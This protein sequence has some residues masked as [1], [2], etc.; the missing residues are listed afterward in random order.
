MCME[1]PVHAMY[2]GSFTHRIVVREG[3]LDIEQGL[4][5]VWR[6][7]TIQNTPDLCERQI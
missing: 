6:E 2:T 1:Q 4:N 5:F 3:G 7:I